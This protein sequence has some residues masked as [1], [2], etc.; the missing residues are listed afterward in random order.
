MKAVLDVHYRG[1]SARAVCLTFD[2]WDQAGP[3]SRTAVELPVPAPYTP[4]RFFEREL[5]CLL[6]VLEA[7]GTTFDTLLIDGFV[8]LRP[9]R[10]GLGE[11]LAEA[12]SHRPSI[13][14]VAKTPLRVADRFLPVLRG[15]GRRP[16]LVSAANCA[17]S[18]AARRVA[19]MHGP[20]RLPTLVA[21]ADR[22][23]RQWRA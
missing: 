14:G 16:L 1:D 2:R 13:I 6:A 20:S 11:H 15:R 12:L 8:H 4:G 5:P 17:L 19:S 18:T 21:L 7:V 3:L 10:T 9:P 22:W 23:S